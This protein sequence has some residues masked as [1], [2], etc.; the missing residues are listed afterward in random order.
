[1][2]L[3]RLSEEERLKIIYILNG[4]NFNNYQQWLEIPLP[5]I[6]KMHRVM[7]WANEQEKRAYETAGR[8][9]RR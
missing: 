9:N 2:S 6:I 8:P 1:M 3:L 4:K 7:K 5:T